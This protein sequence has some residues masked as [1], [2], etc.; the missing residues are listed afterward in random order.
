MC[1]ERENERLRMVAVPTD[2]VTILNTWNAGGLRATGSHDF[3]LDNVWVPDRHTIALVDFSALPYQSGALYALPFI[4]AFALGVTPV[5]LGIARASIDALLALATTKVAAGMQA[6][7]R[8]QSSVQAD[9]A[10]AE[11]LLRSARAYLFDAVGALW[12]TAVLRVQP[13]LLQRTNVRMAIW[14]VAQACKK[15]VLLMYGAAGATATD[16]CAPF[17]AQLRDVHAAGQHLI[18]ATRNMETAGR[19]LLGLEP[20]T[21]RF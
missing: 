16:E 21:A 9:V 15:V 11:T 8:E 5:P 10:R 19:V 1:V 2:Q 6:P 3:E 14:N 4:T 18:F 7:L 20:G 13:S 12:D 17:A